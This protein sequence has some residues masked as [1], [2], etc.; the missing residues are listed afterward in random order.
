[1]KDGR[2]RIREHE[3]EM[4]KLH[5][6]NWS[7]FWFYGIVAISVLILIVT[8]FRFEVREA[9][10]IVRL[11]RSLSIVG[12]NNIAAWWSGILLLIGGIH[13]FDGY[14][15]LRQREPRAA[16]AWASISIILVILSADEI[17]SIHERV[18]WILHLGSWLSKLPFAIILLAMLAYALISLWSAEEQRSKVWPI[19]LGFFVL[20]TVPLQEFIEHNFDWT[21]ET[22]R[23]RSVLEE[24]TELLGMIILLKVSMTNTQ[25]LFGQKGAGASPTFECICLLRFP[26]LTV[27]LPLVVILAYLTAN[28]PDQQ[29]GHPADWFAATVF[30]FAGLAACRRFFADVENISSLEW[31]LAGLCFFA[32]VSSVAIHPKYGIDFVFINTNLRMFVLFIVSLLI[33]SIW[34]LSPRYAR[35]HYMLAAIG[36]GALALFSLS[37][38]HLLFVYGLTQLLALFVYY[39]NSMQNC[40]PRSASG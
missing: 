7:A 38:T 21:Q 3:K 16:R 17:S 8:L 4:N 9:T 32:S 13:A 34:V 26:V 36:M 20:G 14:V 25:G 10:G 18:D 29:R 30:L 27:G 19:F 40:Q 28:L 31:C 23:L 35:R 12:E 6:K 22:M 2:V 24:G 1:M 11:L 33:C 5:D 15:L 39:V 37:Q